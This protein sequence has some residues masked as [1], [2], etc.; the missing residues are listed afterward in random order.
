MRIFVTA[1]AAVLAL[2]LVGCGDK[3]DEDTAE[4]TSAEEAAEEAAEEVEEGDA[5]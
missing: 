4:D 2:S 5:E 3:E 1:A